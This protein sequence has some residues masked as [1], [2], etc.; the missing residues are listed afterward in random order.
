MKNWNEI[1]FTWNQL[2]VLPKRWQAKLAEWRGISTSSISQM[3]KPMWV[4]HMVRAI[5]LAGGAST[6]LW[7]M[8]EIDG[9]GSGPP[10]IFI[11]QF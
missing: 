9:F 11:S 8:V 3:Q 6:L 2:G 1:D 10:K 4:Q 5:Y 7:A